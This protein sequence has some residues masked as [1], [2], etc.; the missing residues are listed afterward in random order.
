MPGGIKPYRGALL[1]QIINT[2]TCPDYKVYCDDDSAIVRGISADHSEVKSHT[3][4]KGTIALLALGQIILTVSVSGSN[5]GDERRMLRMVYKGR[6]Y[7]LGIIDTKGGY[8]ISAMKKDDVKVTIALRR[9]TDNRMIASV[10]GKE[11]RLIRKANAAYRSVFAT[12]DDEVIEIEETNEG[13][14][15]GDDEKHPQE[16]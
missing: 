2:Y 15:R 12:V 7:R 1:E 16:L 5:R 9:L 8:L 10:L 14:S 13:H 6:M 3:L 11:Y 4:P